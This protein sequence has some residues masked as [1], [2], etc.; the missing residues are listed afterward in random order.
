M[1]IGHL[2]SI[3]Y[4][5]NL[6][7]VMLAVV[8]LSLTFPMVFDWSSISSGLRVILI[9]GLAALPLALVQ[10]ELYFLDCFIKRG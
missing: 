8:I 10:V 6:V 9:T 4:F 7:V 2:F 3:V 5:V 1:W